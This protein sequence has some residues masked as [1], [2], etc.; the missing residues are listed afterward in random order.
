MSS[1]GISPITHHVM[2]RCEMNV[3]EAKAKLYIYGNRQREV[4]EK[5]GMCGEEGRRGKARAGEENGG[6]G[7]AVEEERGQ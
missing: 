4:G 5:R 3:W 2:F 1:H 6:K 7:M